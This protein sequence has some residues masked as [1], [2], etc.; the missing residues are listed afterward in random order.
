[1]DNFRYDPYLRLYID[2]SKHD[3]RSGE[4][5]MSDDAHGHLCTATG[6]AW[7]LDGRYFDG[8]DD[9][10]VVP[11][12]LA[13]DITGNLTIFMWANITS[14]SGIRD[15]IGK[16]NGGTAYLLF[17][18]DSDTSFRF[19]S[20][21]LAAGNIAKIDTAGYAGDWHLY[22]GRYNGATDVFIDDK[23]GTTASSP[24]APASTVDDLYIGER[25]TGANDVQ[26][27]IEKIFIYS[28]AFSDMEIPRFREQ[29]RGKYQ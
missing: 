29:I 21:G 13:L 11:D 10:L 9:K 15:F 7:R 16:F 24:L 3:V 27:T 4:S 8:A 19:Y 12:H 20:G 23:K 5:F 17:S 22:T 2:F 1:M 26:A 28:R 6:G 18:T 25:S 14:F